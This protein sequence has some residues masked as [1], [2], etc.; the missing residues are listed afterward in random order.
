LFSYA[1]DIG[2]PDKIMLSN[3]EDLPQAALIQGI[4][5]LHISFVDC[6]ALHPTEHNQQHVY[7]VQ[8]E[9]GLDCNT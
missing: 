3:I 4:N 5:L 6:P 7:T 9:F 8:A 2:T 1:A